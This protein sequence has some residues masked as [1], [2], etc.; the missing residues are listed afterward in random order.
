M[1]DLATTDLSAIY[2]H[3]LKDRM[4]T[5][6]TRSRAR[7]SG[8]TALYRIHYALTRLVAP[9]LAFTA[10]EVWG[11]TAKPAGAP[12]SVHMALLPEPEEVPSGLDASKL[13]NWNRLMEVR[14]VVLKALEEARQSKLIG[15]P[16]EAQVCLDAPPELYPLLEQYAADLPSLFIVSQVALSEGTELRA[17]VERASGTKCERCWKYTTDVG[18]N[19]DFPTVCGACVAA[20]KEMLG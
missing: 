13:A 11:Y 12:E 6:A 7:R 9:L 3:V 14:E 4:Y 18:E 17:T 20:L 15:A 5:A 16:L 1:Y 19:A 8:Q 2:F 10:E